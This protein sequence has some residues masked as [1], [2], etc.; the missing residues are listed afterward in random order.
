MPSDFTFHSE[1]TI[2]ALALALYWQQR[3][4]EA[5]PEIGMG[6]GLQ[7]SCR[8]LLRGTRFQRMFPAQPEQI[9]ASFVKLKIQKEGKL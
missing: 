8:Q 9:I 7:E 4:R 5:S 6:D 3:W 2:D 1:E